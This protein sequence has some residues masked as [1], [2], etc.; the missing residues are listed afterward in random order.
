MVNF[1]TVYIVMPAYNEAENIEEVIESWHAVVE[2][3]N[4]NSK[5][6]ILDDGSK[7]NTFICMSQLQSKYPQLLPI[8]KENSGHGPTCMYAYKYAINNNVDYIFQTDSD[9]Q[10]SP[11]DFWKFYENRKNYDFIIGYRNNRQ[12]GFGRKVISLVLKISTLFIYKIW[13]KDSNS[14]Y[15]MLNSKTLAP[16]LKK[17]PDNFFLANALLAIVIVKYKSTL[18]YKLL[19]LPYQFKARSKGESSYNYFN[20]I[21]VGFNT[22]K[23]FYKTKI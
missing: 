17:I 20:I 1:D 10:T 8:K 15:R 16:L 2:K 23:S 14:P 9:G 12:D 11:D 6:I 22:I 7:D 4:I 3:I 13:V 19:W 21:K 18:N 5:L